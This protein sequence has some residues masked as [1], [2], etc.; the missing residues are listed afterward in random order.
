MAKATSYFGGS[1]LGYSDYD[2]E[3]ADTQNLQHAPVASPWHCTF[4]IVG[5]HTRAVRIQIDV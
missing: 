4:F 5:D 3:R 1:E 2:F